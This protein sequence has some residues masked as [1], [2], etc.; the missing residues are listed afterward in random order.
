MEKV[1]MQNLLSK[2][3]NFLFQF[4]KF[5]FYYFNLLSFIH[6]QLSHPLT[7]CKSL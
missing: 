5:K 6:P 1:K 7:V 2:F 4:F 3:H